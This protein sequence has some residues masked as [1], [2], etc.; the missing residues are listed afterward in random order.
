MSNIILVTG[1][2]GFIG[3]HLVEALVAR[4]QQ[5]RCLVVEGSNIEHL[6]NLGV[7]IF[8]GDL[9]NKGSLKNAVKNVDSV[10]HL[11]AKVRPSGII[12]K[13]GKNKN[14]YS[15]INVTGT[16]NLVDACL[17]SGIQRF[18]Y[19]SSIA[20]T[21]PG[22]GL[23]EDSP[24]CPITKYGK[25]K[26]DAETYILK[27]YK[28]KGLPAIIIRSALTYGPRG[29]AVL[30]LSRF[31]K[32]GILP[33]I[34]NGLNLMPICYVDDLVNASILVGEKGGVGESF[35]VVDKSCSINELTEIIS[36]V[37][38]KNPLKLRI[39]I[40]LAYSCAYLLE[41]LENLLKFKF[42]PF[43]IDFSKE[44]IASLRDWTCY[45]EKVKAQ[46]GFLPSVNLEEGVTRTIRWYK[47]NGM[48]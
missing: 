35:F 6:R 22:V 7:E 18:I 16:K 12:E 19:F 33:M 5:V 41:K 11:A 24:T 17:L 43:K 30:I 21:G 31:I 38:K 40:A 34:G 32:K 9:L 39:P 20:A 44:G 14:I 37:L 26:L 8:Y 10:Y 2:T 28:D 15:E 36:K 1:A 48:L 4:G 47:E 23:T 46:V 27:Q 25:S 45:N 42:A 13:I 29:P 3:S